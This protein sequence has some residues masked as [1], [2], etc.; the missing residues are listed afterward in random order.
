MKARWGVALLPAVLGL[1]LNI[2]LASFPGQ[3]PV[4]YLRASL[5]ILLLLVGVILSALTCLFLALDAGQEQRRADLL[6]K[7]GD[8]RL[9]FLRRLDHELKNP[10]TAIRAGLANI[11]E[12]PGEDARQEAVRSVEMQVMRLSSLSANLR[13][14]ADLEKQEVEHTPVDMVELLRES[15]DLARSQAGGSR[16]L[17]LSIPE[18]PWP[19]PRVEGDQDLLFLAVHN[20]L[21][22]AIKFSRPDDRVEVR[23]FED[24]SS[25]VIEVADTGAGV[26]E[27]ELQHVWEELY[28]G[29][30]A[31]GIPGSGLGLALVRTI[32]ER[33]TG[34]VTMR[35]SFGQGT[36]VRLKLPAVT[37][38]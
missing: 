5:G 4:L 18:A 25:L 9:R 20:L 26:P 16:R 22:N 10:L 7:A 34:Q 2:W 35:S 21:D 36:V 13:K 3:N 27:E 14:L 1:A 12:A 31:R 23:A 17:S 33:H 29:Q 32:A 37:K 6:S 30:A 8:D 19:L 38:R 11:S 24:G 28:R 15:F